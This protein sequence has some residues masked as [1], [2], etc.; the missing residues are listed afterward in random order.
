MNI[1][2]Q[3]WPETKMKPKS[4][5]I[6]QAEKCQKETHSIDEK[7]EPDLKIYIYQ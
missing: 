4:F 6:N 1:K 7:S 2:P 3:N 5:F